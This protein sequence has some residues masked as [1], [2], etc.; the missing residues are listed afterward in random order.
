M[1]A[2]P[3]IRP[4]FPALLVCVL[5]P[6]VL[7]RGVLPALRVID[8]DFPNY[9]VAARIVRDGKDPAKLYDDDWFQAKIY[10]NGIRQ[11]GKFSPFPPPTALLFLPLTGFS[12]LAALRVVTLLNLAM[13]GAAV[14]LVSWTCG[15]SAIES[16][17]FVLLSGVGLI[18]C[19]RLGQLYIGVSVLMLLGIYLLARGREGWGGAC[20]ALPVPFKYFP[21]IFIAY[22]GI[23]GRWKV[24]ISS[25]FVLAGICGASV[26]ILGWPVHAEFLMS[27]LPNHIQS[28]LSQQDPFSVAFQSF[29]SLLR[30][31]FVVDPARNPHP[32]ADAYRIYLVLKPI[33][34]LVLAALAGLGVCRVERR[35]GS[36]RN[37]SISLLGILGLLVA[38]ATATYH[39]VLLWLP[40][41]LLLSYLRG[42]G[43]RLL[44]ALS[45]GFYAAIGLLPYTLVQSLAGQG[46]LSLA[47]Y[48][49]L[50]LM[51]A[52]FLTALAAALGT[53]DDR[54]V[55]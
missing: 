13:L 10:D 38:P 44:F 14:L 48:P 2:M 32:A 4:I 6:F 35:G 21:A 30:R 55:P 49:R 52:L 51:S 54:T 1:T 5:A 23:R 42:S 43:N 47:A 53:G 40:V 18:N 37:L 9:Y 3:P 33:L 15:F 20:L 29:D 27:V 11:R 17:A 8:S 7:G 12:P 50:W 41:G 26:A 24:V 34:I 46:L 36:A 19:L 45:I 28:N 16:A 22:L 39:F 31:P 25:A